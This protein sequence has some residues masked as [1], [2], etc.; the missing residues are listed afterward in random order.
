[1]DSYI[2]LTSFGYEGYAGSADCGPQRSPCTVFYWASVPTSRDIGAAKG[3]TLSPV[4]ITD[5]ADLCLR[6]DSLAVVLSAKEKGSKVERA[7]L[8]A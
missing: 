8:C 4:S 5:E 1:M 2:I 3:T 6:L 7:K